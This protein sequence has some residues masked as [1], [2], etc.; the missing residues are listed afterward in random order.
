MRPLAPITVAPD[1]VDAYGTKW[2][3]DKGASDYA[4]QADRYG[5]TLDVTNIWHIE[6]LN[7]KRANVIVAN[8]KV[9]FESDSI[10]EI[11]QIVD[12]MKALKR[13]GERVE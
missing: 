2:Y 4:Q 3:L 12:K 1:I 5:T 8:Q 9:L 10:D 7:G 13:K 6:E 11:G